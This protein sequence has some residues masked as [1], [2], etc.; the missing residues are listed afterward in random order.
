M[1]LEQ[2][3]RTLQAEEEGDVPGGVRIS[4]PAG[5]DSTALSQIGVTAT[6]HGHALHELGYTVDQVVHD[7][8]DLCQSITS[9]AVERDAPFSVDQFRT[10][11]RCLDNAI[12][13]A[14][15]EFSAQRD[16]SISREHL[17]G[18]NERLGVLV[19]ELRNSLQTATMAFIALESG[20]VPVGG[21]TGAL[22]KRSLGALSRLLERTL[23][24]VRAQAG[25]TD[26]PHAFPLAAFIADAKSIA[27]LGANAR[28][29]AL[30]VPEVDAGIAIVGNRDHL[31][32]A[33]VNLLQNAF[34]F[35]RPDT[36]VTLLA[37]ATAEFVSIDVKDHCGGLPSGFAE[38]M[39]KPF[40]QGNFDRSGLGLGLSIARRTIEAEGGSLTVRNMPGTGCIFTM[41]LP[42][43][44]L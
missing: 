6:A 22:V 19:H 8:G 3:T 25:A 24:E 20:T 34:K 9:L 23:G 26:V 13:D 33:L 29:C 37:Y 44:S 27:A 14:V 42:R 28:G 35:T 40:A 30:A 32:A 41:S 17:A 10:L 36:E 11:N 31:L 15:T 38:K 18:E 43:Y 21:S 7:Y 16:V 1:F 5:G 4:G 12:A 39:F 2:L